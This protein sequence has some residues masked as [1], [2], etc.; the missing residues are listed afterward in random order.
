MKFNLKTLSS[1][2]AF[3]A[4][5]ACGTSANTA[6]GS[7]TPTDPIP[8]SAPSVSISQSGMMPTVGNGSGQSFS[9]TVYNGTK[10]VVTLNQNATSSPSHSDLLGQEIKGPRT[11][12]YDMSGCTRNILPQTA[13]SIQVTPASASGRF[14]LSTSFNGATS[15]Q[16]YN[17]TQLVEYGSLTA[18]NGFIVGSST[19]ST[20]KAP[21]QVFYVSIPFVLDDD[22]SSVVANSRVATVNPAQVTCT[23]TK[24]RK[25]SSCT[26]QLSFKG[27]IYSNTISVTGV[28]LLAAQS[29]Q[30]SQLQ[31]AQLQASGTNGFTVQQNVLS[32][33]VANIINDGANAIV[34]ATTPV[35]IHVLNTGLANTAPLQITLGGSLVMKSGANDSCTNQ[36]L[37]QNS[38]AC[39]FTVT[40]TATQNTQ[41]MIT[42][43]SGNN[44][45]TITLFELASASAPSL[46]LRANGDFTYILN[47]SSQTVPLLVTNTSTTTT[48]LNTL[49]FT[50]LSGAFSYGTNSNGNDCIAN[51]ISSLTVGESCTLMLKYSPTGVNATSLS[52]FNFYALSSYQGLN[53]T[54]TLT[55]SVTIPYSSI[56]GNAHL[57][58]TPAS[59]IMSPIRADGESSIS[60]TVT[61]KNDGNTTATGIQ[62]IPN[63]T[64]LES[65]H[66]IQI[67]TSGT[68]NC[69]QKS[70][71]QVNESCVMVVN[72]GPV[73]QT[74]VESAVD[75]SYTFKSNPGSTGVTTTA[76]YS[77]NIAAYA[78]AFIKV[79]TPNVI[80]DAST[81]F[82][83]TAP[84][85]FYPTQ[86]AYVHVQY[87]YHN[88]G[89]TAAESFNVNSSSMAPG[90]EIETVA[91]VNCTTGI[92]T[93]ELAVAESCV[94][95]VRYL[96]TPYLTDFGLGIKSVALPLTI[97]TLG[98]SYNDVGSGVNQALQSNTSFTITAQPWAS[99]ANLPESSPDIIHT[100]GSHQRAESV[101]FTLNSQA[102]GGLPVTITLDNNYLTQNNIF[103]TGLNTCTINNLPG[104]CTINLNYDPN[105]PI[106]TPF[107]LPYSI[108]GTG[109]A[110]GLTLSGMASVQLH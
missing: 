48:T 6:A 57:S 28:P 24:F 72:F 105:L 39:Q 87:T 2:L 31:D 54:Q 40:T 80:Y 98:Y 47:G 63:L 32:S 95:S 44:T 91:G 30:S 70:S 92:G 68:G 96:S 93:M 50:S 79:D 21:D 34:S 97:Y 45:N 83:V 84:Y 37:A 108:Q 27:G 60:Q 33:N 78:A 51:N 81:N 64:Q 62:F 3:S 76:P 74:L 52:N 20:V 4:L 8:N 110:A 53:G 102:I 12:L 69:S 88:I 59:F 55:E 103:P 71:L 18:N 11:A 5:V 22:Y 19:Y 58:Y 38:G 106:T 25:G 1:L 73:N 23:D 66:F 43:N 82:S 13:C 26:A 9:L 10:E 16:T 14:V 100:D 65:N 67:G 107:Q 94:V 104:T 89:V 77:A 17:A 36:V 86:G 15:G 49:Q 85:S 99:V 61:V 29:L 7:S 46:S 101:V 90:G 35:T 75:L 109:V 42:I 41:D 56:T